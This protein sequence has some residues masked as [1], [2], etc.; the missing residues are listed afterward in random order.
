MMVLVVAGSVVAVGLG[1]CGFVNII[2][3]GRYSRRLKKW[4]R[5]RISRLQGRTDETTEKETTEQ[6]IDIIDSNRPSI[7]SEVSSSSGLDIEPKSPRRSDIESHRS[8][9]DC[10]NIRIAQNVKSKGINRWEKKF[11]RQP[12]EERPVVPRHKPLSFPSPSS[13]E[14]LH[15][16]KLE[17]Q[18][19]DAEALHFRSEANDLDDLVNEVKGK[20]RVEGRPF[21]V[22]HVPGV[23]DFPVLSKEETEICNDAWDETKDVDEVLVN[24]FNLP[25]T[26]KDLQTLSPKSWLND[27]VIN[28]YF[29]LI[30]KRSKTIEGLPMVYAFSTYFFTAL[31]NPHSKSRIHRWTKGVNLFEYD[32]VLVPL[33][34]GAHWCL[35]VI[36]NEKRQLRDYLQ[37]ESEKKYESKYS[38]NNYE[39]IDLE[40][41]P[42]QMN[43]F[44]CGVFT[45]RFA[46]YLSRRAP[47]NFNQR[48]MPS[49]R[50]RIVIEIVTKKLM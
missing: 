48:H 46:E 33:H 6:S 12:A 29:S 47:F 3:R 20:L 35:A 28:F 41:C 44:D 24:E 18:R 11:N 14:H 49:Y 31:T 30:V 17:S 27:E 42:K 1:F 15:K 21:D 38:V 7:V 34:L 25:I 2:F 13:A 9:A 50:K 40:P 8:E 5:Y 45:C 4:I 16:L 23:K 36:D 39:L 32:L 26:R 10:T 19:K 37:Q 22:V 43:G